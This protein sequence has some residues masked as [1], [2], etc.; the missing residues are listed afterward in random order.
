MTSEYGTYRL[1][2]EPP[3]DQITP[4]VEMTLSGEADMSQMLAMFESFLQAA[5]YVLK[6]DL[7]VIERATEYYPWAT[8][9]GSEFNPIGS[10]FNPIDFM[11]FTANSDDVITFGDK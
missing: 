11:G 5:G 6:G 7:R 8:Y 4:S 9:P 3:A 2:F 1:T 10:E